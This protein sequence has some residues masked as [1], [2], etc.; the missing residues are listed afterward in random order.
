MTC[1][2][3]MSIL[4]GGVRAVF[5]VGVEGLLRRRPFPCEPTVLGLVCFFL[6]SMLNAMS[7]VSFLP[8]LLSWE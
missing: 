1:L 4:R 6:G 3:L 7:R 5:A 8:R 2:T